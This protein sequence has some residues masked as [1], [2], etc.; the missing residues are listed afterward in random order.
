MRSDDMNG[1]QKKKKLI[2]IYNIHRNNAPFKILAYQLKIVLSERTIPYS[3]IE[4]TS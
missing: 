4:T 3:I 1:K 2:I